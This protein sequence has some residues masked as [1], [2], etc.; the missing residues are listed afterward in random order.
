MPIDFFKNIKA[1]LKIKDELCGE[2]TTD[3]ATGFYIMMGSWVLFKENGEGE[4]QSWANQNDES[5]YN[6]KGIFI[7]KRL[8]NNKIEI[9]NKAANT[10]EIIE[11]KIEKINNRLELSNIKAN[12][13]G[14]VTLEEFWNFSQ[15]MF[16]YV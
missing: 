10:I 12:K 3:D 11:Y 14:D 7:W 1:L 5:G 4:Y 13:I 2:W 6:L 15:V 9:T 8:T 16:K